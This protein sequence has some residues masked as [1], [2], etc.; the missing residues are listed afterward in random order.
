MIKGTTPTFTLTV[1]DAD[2]TEA[3]N[4][5][6]T[7]KQGDILIS[8]S[9]DD[10]TVAEHTINV[11]LTQEETLKFRSGKLQVQVNMTYENGGRACT[12]I[13]TVEVGNNLVESVLV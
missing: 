11:Y 13:A 10:I 2:L 3:V 6:V 5:Y 8:K 7:F 9:G 12:E 1:A 4:V